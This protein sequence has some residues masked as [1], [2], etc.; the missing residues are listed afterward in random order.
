LAVIKTAFNQRRKTLRNSLKPLLGNNFAHYSDPIF[1]RRPEEL[2][3]DDFINMIIEYG[4][5]DGAAS[6]PPPK[7]N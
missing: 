6:S 2:S 1:S 7:T 3:V 5:D 4:M